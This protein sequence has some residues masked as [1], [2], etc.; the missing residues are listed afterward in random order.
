MIK[1]RLIMLLWK[2][3]IWEHTRICIIKELLWFFFIGQAGW[4]GQIGI[5]PTIVFDIKCLLSA[6]VSVVLCPDRL[7][8]NKQ[9][10]IQTKHIS[11][12]MRNFH[13]TM[14]TIIKITPQS[15]NLNS[16]HPLLS[17]TVSAMNTNRQKQNQ[18]KS[19]EQL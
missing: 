6:T 19:L 8:R 9:L 18:S 17:K 11:K 10:L 13:Q 5:K 2:C 16:T 3:I 14:Q 1:K 4:K 12:Y 7:Y 15:I